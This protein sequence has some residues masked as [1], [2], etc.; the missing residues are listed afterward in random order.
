MLQ[1]TGDAPEVA[2]RMHGSSGAREVCRCGLDIHD[3]YPNVN[4]GQINTFLYPPEF[5]TDGKIQ[6]GL[7]AAGTPSSLIKISVYI[8]GFI[9]EAE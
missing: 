9:Y 7:E 8:D 3:G 2:L 1:I 4:A 6:I 5:T